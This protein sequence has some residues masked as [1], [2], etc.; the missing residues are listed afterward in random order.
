MTMKQNKLPCG[1]LFK[2]PRF[3]AGRKCV[4]CQLNLEKKQTKTN[5]EDK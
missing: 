5:K 4:Q 3:C 2:L 1:W